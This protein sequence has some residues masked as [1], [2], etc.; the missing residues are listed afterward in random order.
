[1]TL[2]ICCIYLHVWD[3]FELL[4]NG[5]DFFF[6][7]FGTNR[8]GLIRICFYSPHLCVGFLFFALHPPPPSPP[9]SSVVSNLSHS[10]YYLHSHSSLL[11]SHTHHITLISHSH[12]CS[13][14]AEGARVVAAWGPRP[15]CY[16]DLHSFPLVL[17]VTL[18]FP[19]IYT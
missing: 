3:Y 7:Y 17:L 19:F 11:T 8:L 9:S 14:W 12:H 18:R 1:M 5:L 13:G 10:H 4:I 2:G 16:C 6:L 15:R